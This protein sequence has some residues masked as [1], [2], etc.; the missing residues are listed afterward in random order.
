VRHPGAEQADEQEWE[1]ERRHLPI[2]IDH[3]VCSRPSRDGTVPV[4]EMSESIWQL[5][6]ESCDRLDVAMI[7]ANQ[8]LRFKR[9]ARRG[10]AHCLMG[11]S[12]G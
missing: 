1:R 5:Y 12:A 6:G 11:L 7:L 10:V 9:A 8:A 4:F 2:V 3:G